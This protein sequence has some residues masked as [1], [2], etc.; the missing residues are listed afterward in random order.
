M[1]DPDDDDG[2]RQALEDLLKERP[3]AGIV[4]AA[5]DRLADDT[6]DVALKF[7]HL[8]GYHLIGLVQA[9]LQEAINLAAENPDAT[10]DP[11]FERLQQAK[12]TARCRAVAR[13][14]AVTAAGSGKSEI[15]VPGVTRTP[16]P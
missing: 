7:S 16:D 15:G 5:V 1:R 13:R 9:L 6:L 14:V 10:L 8:S 3:S 4:V 12:A 11:E 2:A